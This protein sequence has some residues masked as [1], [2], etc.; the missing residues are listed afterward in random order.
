MSSE[1]KTKKIGELLNELIKEKKWEKNF[2]LEKLKNDWG[3]V[4]G[5][6]IAGHTIPKFIKGKKLFIEVDSPIWSTQLNYL[7]NQVMTTINGYYK[8]EMIN[9]VFFSIKRVNTS[10]D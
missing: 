10:L 5:K 8:V 1:I 6:N 7:R 9:D 4:V 3:K 2:A